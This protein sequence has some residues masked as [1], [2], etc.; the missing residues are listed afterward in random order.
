MSA[1]T[2]P[3]RSGGRRLWSSALGLLAAA[4][5]AIGVNMLADR[6]LPRARVDLTEQHLYTLSNGTRQVLAGLKDPIT[7]RLFYSRRLGA[8]IPVYGAYADRVREML[9]EYAGLSNGKVKLE[10]LDPEPFSE[11]ED[12]AMAL[13]LQGVP[14][15]QSG[16]QVY[17][18]LSGTNLVD[19][20]RSIGF[21]QPD[22]ERFLEYDLTRLV[23]DLSNPTRPVIGVMTTLPLNGDPRAMMMRN[24]ALGQPAVAMTQ[25]RQFFTVK[26]IPLDAQVIEPEVQV[27]LLAHPQHLTDAAQYAV[28]QFVMRGGKLMVLVD[29]HSES[30][31]SKPGPTGQPPTDTSSSLDRLLNAWGIE[32]P[33][34][35]V[36]LDLRGAWRVRANPGDRQRDVLTRLIEGEA[37]GERLTAPELIHNCIFLLN[38]GHE[39]TTNLI[40][41]GLVTLALNPAE[42]DKLR[43]HPELVKSAVEEVLRYESSNQL[44][45]RSTTE[46]VRLGGVDLPAQTLITV[47]IGAA[48][49]DPAQFPDPDRFDIARSPNRHLAFAS[50]IHV[51][52]GASLARLEGQVALSRFLA[53]FPDYE[54]G[55]VK[56]GGRARFRGF[57]KIGCTVN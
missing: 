24:P 45:N 18:G 50:G 19:D 40:G 27:L 7:L 55:E 4:V 54:I 34:D 14:V 31:A 36:V 9:S 23:Y 6:L 48:N 46:P 56:R 47:C 42:K 49:R 26:D 5:L 16:E 15:D 22:R 37:D 21:F 38:A 8:A 51:C 35:K 41:N 17:F 1:T 33:S 20:E 2:Q 28:D 29:P 44:G 39:T 30:Q 12:R 13:G 11:L 53:R 10:V 57:L 32:A 43:K 3:P 25:L 52:A